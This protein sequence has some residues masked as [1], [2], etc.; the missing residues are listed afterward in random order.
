MEE[1]DN[2]YELRT[3]VQK[4]VSRFVPGRD[5]DVTLKIGSSK[6]EIKCHKHILI[7]SPVIKSWIAKCK[8]TLDVIRGDEILFL[9]A[10]AVSLIFYCIYG[11]G[12]KKHPNE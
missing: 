2:Y 10:I 7:R 11:Y 5:P 12:L 9:H 4:L 6:L 1:H 3:K 8:E